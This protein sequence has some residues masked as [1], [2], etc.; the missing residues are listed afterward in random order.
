[1]LFWS[2]L[3][4][5]QEHYYE[6]VPGAESDRPS[7]LQ[8]MVIK[9][10]LDVRMSTYAKKYSEMVVHKNIPSMR[11]HLTRTIVFSKL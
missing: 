2:V 4:T 11:H 3:V 7:N 6:H 5:L 1:M 10:Y 8:K 9:K